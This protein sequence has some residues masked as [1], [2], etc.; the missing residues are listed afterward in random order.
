MF[1]LQLLKIKIYE[2]H[3]GKTQIIKNASNKI[4]L[5]NRK[6]VAQNLA[7]DKNTLPDQHITC[8][9]QSSNDCRNTNLLEHKQVEIIY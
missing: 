8:K 6:M 4:T 7:C 9:N 3:S 5:K 2:K 1:S